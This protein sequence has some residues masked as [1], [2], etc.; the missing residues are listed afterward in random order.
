[1]ALIIFNRA[2][3]HLGKGYTGSSPILLFSAFLSLLKLVDQ[4]CFC[5]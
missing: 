4:H 1:M 2:M 5:K 3:G